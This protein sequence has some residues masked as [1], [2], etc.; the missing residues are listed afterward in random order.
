LIE[1]QNTT[2][3]SDGIISR[4]INRKISLRITNF[5]LYIYPDISPLAITISCFIVA[6]LGGMF[7]IFALPLIGGIVI[8]FSSI[9]D[10]CDGE[11]ARIKNKSSKFGGFL[12]S[13]FDRYADGLILLAIIYYLQVHW[14]FP[15]LFVP[16]YLLGAI[17]ILG[18]LL[19]SY[20]ATKSTQILPLEFS[21][22][23]E[24][25][26]F[27]Y[28]V[29]MIGS[30]FAYFWYFALFIAVIYIACITHIKVVQRIIQ[31]KKKLDEKRDISDETQP[32]P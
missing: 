25:R 27:R 1:I 15:G 19:I 8:Q 28:F 16:M 32:A 12:D 20:T 2:K 10:G 14:S 22:T 18:S 17:A 29:L 26:D 30:I 4:Y 5:L 3:S 6:L 11:I 13:I 9:I 31:L 21:R 23:I 24:G 7:F